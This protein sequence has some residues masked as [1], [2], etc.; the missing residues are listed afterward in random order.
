MSDRRTLC[1][2]SPNSIS[3]FLGVPVGTLFAISQNVEHYYHNRRIEKTSNGKVR[4]LDVPMWYLKKLLRKLHRLIQR[5]RLFS[6]SAH[7]GVKGRSTFSS[8]KQH[9]GKHV[10]A[11]R[12]AANC[13]PS[14]S[15]E[16][17]HHQLLRLGFTS[18]TARLL[19]GLLT[20]RGRIPQGSPTSCD[21]LNLYLWDMDDQ[22]VRF[23]GSNICY[24][25]LADDHVVSGQ[26]QA[27]VESAARFIEDRLMVEGLSVNESKKKKSGLTIAP[28]RQNVHSIGVNHPTKTRIPRDV[29]ATYREFGIRFVG[30]AKAVSA[31]SLERVAAMRRTL[32]GYANYCRQAEISPYKRLKRLLSDGDR[33]V[34]GRLAAE[35]VTRSKKWWVVTKTRNR[36]LEYVR[37]WRDALVAKAVRPVERAFAARRHSSAPLTPTR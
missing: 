14:V 11:I 12:D 34:L 28:E 15:T 10:V 3:E 27:T 19:T 25:R 36:P 8:A 9:L 17:F 22:I 35:R 4:E 6:S 37:L 1:E 31:D 18:S 16:R 33:A 30:A 5:E 20:C 2:I 13:Y 7:G 32:A 29:A 23:W 21:A 24:T 26:D